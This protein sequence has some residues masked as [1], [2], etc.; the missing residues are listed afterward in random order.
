MWMVTK[1]NYHGEEPQID[2][3]WI[4]HKDGELKGICE[5]FEQSAAEFIAYSLNAQEDGELTR[6]DLGVI[7]AHDT[8]LDKLVDVVVDKRV[9]SWM[10][11]G[12]GE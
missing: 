3:R 9:D 4:V 6:S 11:G 2:T 5:C 8:G 10:E 12:Q 7:N 1:R